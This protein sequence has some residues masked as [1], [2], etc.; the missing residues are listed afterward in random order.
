MAP[1]PP[2]SRGLISL[3]PAA[4]SHSQETFENRSRKR[5][6]AMTVHAGTLPILILLVMAAV[7]RAPADPAQPPGL[8]FCCTTDN[9]LYRVLASGGVACP[10]YDTPAD[11]VREAA[12]GSGV[13]ILADG[14]PENLTQVEP[15]VFD[16]A[17]RKNL[18][19]YLEYPSQ[20]PDLRVGPPKEIKS[21]RGVVTSE[22]FGATLPPMEIVTLHGGRYVPVKA[23]NPQLVLATV[24]GV[25]T[26]VFGLKDTPAEPLLFDHPRGNLLVATSQ[27]SG[28]VRGRSMP[29]E[30]WRT[31]WQTILNRLQ[32]GAP[33]AK[34]RW[35]AAVRASYGPEEPLP[36]DA[37]QQA[38]RRSAEWIVHSRI[39][40]HPNWPQ[41]VLDRSLSYNTVREMPAADWPLGDGSLG[42][43]EGFSSTI[44]AD[45]S[46]PMRYAVRNDCMGEVAMLMALSATTG[47][48]A[49]HEEIAAKLL[50][51]LFTNSGLAGGPRA[52]R[53]SPSY[54][55]VGW[56]L[57]HPD[58]YW[59]DDNARALLGVGAV[60]ALLKQP[61]WD[62]AIARCILG[63]FRTTGIYGFRP[64]CVTEKSLQEK[65][66]KP[67]WTD[68]HVHYSPHMQAWIWA[69]YLWLYEQ[70]RFEPLLAR[71]K[72]G[73]RMMMGAYPDRWAWCLRSGTIERSRLLLP[74]AWLVRVEDTPEHRRWLRQIAEDLVSLQDASGALREVIGDGGPGIHANS[75]FGTRETSLIQTDG[76]P[77]CDMLYSC[78]FALIGLHEAAAATGD[79]F[80]AE[81]EEKLARFLCRIQIRSEAHPELDGAWYRAFNFRRWEYWASNADWEWG[82]WCTESGWC[83]P[84]IAGTLALRQQKTSLWSVVHQ[85]DLRTHFDRLRP[86]MLPDEAVGALKFER[87]KIMQATVGKPLR[88]TVQADRRY[89]GVGPA[90]LTDGIL[91]P[92]DHAAPEWLGFMGTDLEAVVDLGALVKIRRLGLN[93]LE[94]TRVGVF[95]PKQVEFAASRDEMQFQ[96]VK[97]IETS[98]PTEH[99]AAHTETLMAEG[100]D[101]IGRYVR[102][103]ASHPGP[104][105]EWV[106]RGSVPAWIFAGEIVVVPCAEEVP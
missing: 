8:V 35:T 74:L 101:V 69:C 39:L 42:V 55:L 91:G 63:N 76:D 6:C 46:Q 75:H 31:I 99:V 16:E 102:V 97:R 89:P 83:Q 23:Q 36:P 41:E 44:R 62:E 104:L 21:Q 60:S 73:M 43:L 20:L 38:L 30:A 25:D 87:S 1:L 80:Y 98:P 10:R 67:L 57:D 100:L 4:E 71:T 7:Q 90:G 40:R 26:A 82:P 52:D 19:L 5:M 48:R 45:G 65:G 66:W 17:I 32:P 85:A 22:I 3:E 61:R 72:T 56:A 95:L 2:G 70:T 47:G 34:L 78:N 54:G 12:V 29:A 58:S 9:D 13:L 53:S 88:L 84:W 86:Q 51:Y 14:H 94:S 33:A 18:R 49:K 105:P 59:G 37:E 68:R 50:D 96:V 81:A 64:A 92:A 93:C 24:A 106:A 11:A 77:V 28:F 27:L 103:R 79:P 15:A